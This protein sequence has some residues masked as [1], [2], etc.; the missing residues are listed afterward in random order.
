[1]GQVD[2]QDTAYVL[3]ESLSICDE[4]KVPTATQKPRVLQDSPEAFVERQLRGVHCCRCASKVSSTTS[5]IE[6]VSQSYTMTRS[7]L[8]NFVFA[9][10]VECR[11]LDL[12]KCGIVGLDQSKMTFWSAA[13]ALLTVSW[14]PLCAEGSET[15][16]LPI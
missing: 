9:I 5:K 6:I 16:R 11:P 1:M 7:H 15:T 12:R 4:I 13:P 2:C 3:L 10:A 14:P 8:V